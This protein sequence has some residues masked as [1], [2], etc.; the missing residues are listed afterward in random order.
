M[1]TLP[2]RPGRS[3]PSGAQATTTGSLL[4]GSIPTRSVQVVRP[5]AKD[6]NVGNS[7]V[8][9]FAQLI[10]FGIAMVAI[11]SGI[12][13]IAF[14]GDTTSSDFL[15]LAIGGI[16]SAVLALTMIEFQIKRGGNEIQNV[17]DYM[18][19]V[20]FF[21]AGLGVLYAARYLIGL[22]ANL[23]VDLFI[24]GN[25]TWADTGWEPAAEA[26]YFQ[27]GALVLLVFAERMYLKRLTGTTTFGWS[28]VTFTPLIVAL[29]GMG[30]WMDWSENIVSWELGISLIALVGLSMWLSVE[31]NSSIV[32]SVV[33][34]TSG[35]IPLFYE[36]NN[37][38]SDG[39]AISLLVF[40]I[41][42]QGWMAAD[43]R[44]KQGIIQWTSA[45]LIGEVILVMIIAGIENDSFDWELIL[46]PL[47][48]YSLP[49][50]IQPYFT[51]QNALWFAMLFAYFP[52]TLKRRIP[53]M[54]IG[55]AGSLWIIE[56]PAGILPWVM[57]LIMLPYLLIFSKVTRTWVANSSMLAV[58]LSY[59]LQTYL[60]EDGFNPEIFSSIILLTVLICGEMG[61][62][63]GQLSDWAHFWGLGI[64]VLSEPVLYGNDPFVPWA[65]VAYALISSFLMMKNAQE[66]DSD[67]KAFTASSTVV[68]SIGIT[69][70]LSFAGRLE[71]P[72]SE[73]MEDA[74][75]GFNIT[76]AFVGMLIYG[77]FYKFKD[78]ELD[79]GTLLMNAND[80]RKKMMP[81]F[82]SETGS[83]KVIDDVSDS[84][85]TVIKQWGP[86]GRASLIGPMMLFSIALFWMESSIITTQIW[87]V[88]LMVIP[89]G[90]IVKEVLDDNEASSE[91]RMIA[92]WTM[93][94]VA[95]PVSFRLIMNLDP[96]LG[97]NLS[98][99]VFDLMLLSGPLA[100]SM[101]LTKRGLNE[102]KINPSADVATLLGLLAIGFLDSS[103]GILFLGMYY[104]AFS[105][106]LMH[107]Q[108]FVLCFAPA[109]LILQGYR[110][111]TDG[112]LMKYILESIDFTSYDPMETTILGMT[113][114]ACI[115]ISISALI[116]IVKAV[117]DRRNGNVDVKETPLII[118][119]IWLFIGVV[120]VLPE[121]SWVLLALSLLVAFC[122]W[123][124]G[125]ISIMTIM[126]FTF[127]LSFMIGFEADSNFN[128]VGWELVS[129]S[130][131]GSSLLS[132]GM[133][134]M[135]SRGTM[136]K[137]ADEATVMENTPR[138]LSKFV[139]S[140]AT[141]TVEGR[142]ELEKILY[143]CS[144]VGL[145]LSFNALKGLGTVIGAIWISW[146]VF[147]RGQKYMALVLP[148]L[149][150]MAFWNLTI[151]LDLS[152]SA[153]T[154]TVGLIL[155]ISGILMTIIS[156]KPEIAWKW[157]YFAWEDEI[158]YY[159][160]IDRVGQLAI[161]YFL[162]GIS[163]LF[164]EFELDSM[165][166]IVWAIYLSG[167]A[168]QGFRDETETPWRR[169][170]G[171]FGSLFSLFMLSTTLDDIYTY[172][173][174]MG[175]GVVALGFGFAYIARMGEE[176]QLFEES[177]TEA[178][179]EMSDKERPVEPKEAKETVELPEAQTA[180]PEEEEED[181]QEFLEEIEEG[182]VSEESFETE[183]EQVVPETVP[184]EIILNPEILQVIQ[185][186]LQN[187]PH[188]GFK[189]LVN[190]IG[191][192]IKI[193]FVKSE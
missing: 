122:A 171:S 83:W 103:G 90:L 107:R 117:Q 147:T 39:G 30:P 186:Q 50:N 21:F 27:M 176:N 60:M 129:Y 170:L 32:F 154:N 84:L 183:K 193:D 87:W 86:L 7:V 150:S 116:L 152:D 101:I 114:F 140:F 65:I 134:Y 48:Q 111:T 43:S 136:Y 61:R 181:L 177:Y 167:I 77:V 57:T 66:S 72:L 165:L 10:L 172:V 47:R 104:L 128:Y 160:W 151:E 162:G 6:Q 142:K 145:T 119:A 173:T 18:I 112:T 108:N 69:I 28:M 118:P 187:T 63:K 153:S 139:S 149:L 105:R 99:I 42:I 45:L 132:L 185:Y 175:M 89:L 131:L 64:L 19:G 16:V 76:L 120:G 163:S 2:S 34:V 25:E 148:L 168:I 179:K 37:A 141:G 127:L 46:G 143:A 161:C 49:E 54:P 38:T 1:S 52:A 68:A 79:I 3:T 130:L 124:V 174:W 14:T 184:F 74:L 62:T 59:F 133:Y 190:V 135:C 82:D 92:T 188:I 41:G 158:E 123:L 26:I 125:R 81:V 15:F 155:T 24:D 180:D 164:A 20:S 23:G 100:V 121:A 159:G 73:G 88:I 191:G 8:Q 91:G 126:P 93:F 67:E 9:K 53:Y 192:N 137:W 156:A 80:S 33:A 51:L 71:V 96:S 166:W 146:D 22:A 113:R 169:G 31:A 5:G 40:I 94:V 44:L 144:V 97:N 95:L 178:L 189:P 110:L 109:M 157:K 115:I 98:H 12:F 55:L 78:F 36:L 85:D 13:A 11:W 4:S 29:I 35:L 56:Q 70:L 138:Q 58:C 75:H 106:S 17:H 182:I 102:N